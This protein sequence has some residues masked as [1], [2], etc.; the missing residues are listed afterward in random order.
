MNSQ[1]VRAAQEQEQVSQ[2]VNQSVA[3]IRDLS[4]TILEQAGESERVGENIAE[5]SSSQQKI[6]SQF[7]V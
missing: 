6:V 1:I 4:A 2:E 5:L 3:K 7:K